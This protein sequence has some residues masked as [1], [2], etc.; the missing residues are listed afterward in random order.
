[1]ITKIASIVFKSNTDSYMINNANCGS[2]IFRFVNFFLSNS[3]MVSLM[4]APFGGFIDSSIFLKQHLK[5]H[6]VK[7]S[8]KILPYSNPTDNSR[9]ASAGAS[10]T[11]ERGALYE[12][13]A[14]T[15]FILHGLGDVLMTHLTF[16]A[17]HMFSPL[18]F[19][20]TLFVLAQS[21][22]LYLKSAPS[23]FKAIFAL[24]SSAARKFAQ[25]RN[26]M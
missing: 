19:M 8:V 25:S 21:I 23:D 22:K 14:G 2:V 13:E 12:F 1:M 20:E 5:M 15:T 11:I 9:V 7:G 24:G 26:A 6:I 17:K 4:D 3:E 18:D 16:F 10:V